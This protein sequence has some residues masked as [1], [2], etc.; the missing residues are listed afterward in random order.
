MSVHAPV[1]GAFAHRLGPG[2]LKASALGAGLG[3]AQ[4]LILTK[5]FP[6]IF[7]VHL[8]AIERD[9]ELVHDVCEIPVPH[10]VEAA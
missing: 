1:G 2:A 7:C 3:C 10:R 4:A 8:A 9:A 6:I 5:R